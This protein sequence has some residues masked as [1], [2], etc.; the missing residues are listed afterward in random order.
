MLL[1]TYNP[2]QLINVDINFNF[3]SLIIT[4]SMVDQGYADSNPPSIISFHY[5][6]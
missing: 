2:G 3:I 4:S 5:I 6:G 1:V